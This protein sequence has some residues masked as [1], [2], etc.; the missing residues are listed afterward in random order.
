MT[1]RAV[2][3]LIPV[4]HTRPPPPPPPPPNP[5]K[6]SIFPKPPQHQHQFFTNPPRRDFIFTSLLPLL[7]YYL[8]NPPA[9][10]NAF[11]LGISG[12]KEWLKE[13]KKK[14]YKVL[15]APIDASRESLH[16]AYRLLTSPDSGSSIEDLGE[17]QRLLNAAA[18]DCVPQERNSFVAFQAR[19]GVEVCTFRLI[20]KN[21]SSLLDDRDPVKL[22]A[23]AML[24]DLIRSFTFLDGVANNG[25][26]PFG[27]NRQK[28]QDGL[29]GTISALDKLERGIMDC[30]GV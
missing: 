3:P 4:S 13:Q 25:D 14:A 27:S 5:S 23:E 30:L 15:L 24:G 20:V 9:P 26:L 22:E 6:T 16:A 12:P 1:T 21:A 8:F 19:T 2:L 10:A 18:R 11:S 29:L 28:L 17:V 7:P